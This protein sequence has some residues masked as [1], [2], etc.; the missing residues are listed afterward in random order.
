LLSR[1]LIA[2]Y[3]GQGWASLSSFIF[4]PVYLHYLGLEAYGLIGFFSMLQ[5][6]FTLLDAGLGPTL[7]REMARYTGGARSSQSIRDLLTS[8]ELI[9]FF[10]A[11]ILIF[12]LWLASNFI[13]DWWLVSNELNKE[14]VENALFLMGIAAALRVIEG[15]YRSALL[16]LQRQVLFNYLLIGSST[17]K[18]VGAVLVLASID[19]S[20]TAFFIWQ[21]LAS[22]LTVLA[23]AYFSRTSLP[24]T[25]Q[26]GRFSLKEI[27]GVFS[28]AK[29]MLFITT[30]SLLLMQVDKIILSKTL[31][32]SEFGIYSLASTVAM[33]VLILV[34]PVT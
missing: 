3:I 27:S 14:T 34:T 24:P 19:A 8:V 17:L 7:G 15:I 20:I 33:A 12:L 6:W 1:N 2:N 22:T 30:L 26:N 10:V 23:L 11:S 28:Y 31:S 5:A 21:V 32:L 29:G 18:S 13:A 4:L 25:A 9:S 16:G